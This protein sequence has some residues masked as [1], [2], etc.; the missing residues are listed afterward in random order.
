M[1]LKLPSVGLR[2]RPPAGGRRASVLAALRLPYGIAPPG[3][4]APPMVEA[5]VQSIIARGDEFATDVVTGVL[6]A[7]PELAPAVIAAAVPTLTYPP[8]AVLT[9]RRSRG[10]IKS[11]SH[12]SGF[13]FIEC[14][15]LHRIFGHDVFLHQNQ[16]GSFSCNSAV[17]FAVALNKDGK[18][19]AYDL[20]PL[21][22]MGWAPPNGAVKRPLAQPS[23]PIGIRAMALRP[24]LGAGGGCGGCDSAWVPSSG[25]ADEQTELGSYVGTIKSFSIRNGYGFIECDTLKEEG[26]PNDVFLHHT[27]KAGLDVGNVVAFTAYLNKAGQPQ[28]KDIVL[29]GGAAKRVRAK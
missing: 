26:H 4:A 9:K 29:Q 21:V 12:K 6:S 14:A 25:H 17:S 7:R 1:G 28:A 8:A 3:R 10:F 27:Q 22:P 15:E 18:P 11:F 24:K 23:Q 5:R 20:L 13:G 19:Q 16:L 2:R